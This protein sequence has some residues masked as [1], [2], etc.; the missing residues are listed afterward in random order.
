MQITMYTCILLLSWLGAKMIVS[1]TKTTGQ[2]MS[3]LTYS[4]QILMGLMMLSMVFVMITMAKSSAE[5][6]LEV[7]DE[8][9]TIKNPKNPIKEV[10]DGSISSVAF[11]SPHLRFSFIVPENNTFF[12]KTIETSFLRVSIS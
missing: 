6:I 12:C 11:L 8:E 1:N 4:T 10:K 3:F 7:L 2:L 5:R 9:S